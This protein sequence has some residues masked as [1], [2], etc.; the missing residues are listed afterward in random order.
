MGRDSRS[1]LPHRHEA[2]LIS[3]LNEG[4]ILKSFDIPREKHPAQ[5]MRLACSAV[6]RI[7]WFR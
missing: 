2:E 5:T 1:G 6:A 3:Q 7:A 4:T